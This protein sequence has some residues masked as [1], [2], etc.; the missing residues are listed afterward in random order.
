MLIDLYEYDSTGFDNQNQYNNFAKSCFTTA[1]ATNTFFSLE[2]FACMSQ[3][4]STTV[5]EAISTITDIPSFPEECETIDATS[6]IYQSRIAA[7]NYKIEI[8][9]CE[10]YKDW[11]RNELNKKCVFITSSI[12]TFHS[13][14]LSKLTDETSVQPAILDDLFPFKNLNGLLGLEDMSDDETIE[15]FTMRLKDNFPAEPRL[16]AGF[17]IDHF[18]VPNH[19]PATIAAFDALT[20]LKTE[21]EF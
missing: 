20:M 19:C 12:Q 17:T 10:T 9:D 6:D 3:G 13:M 2:S 4:F 21:I 18:Q 7:Y 15:G 5:T 1:R 14:Q 8:Q 11:V 16:D